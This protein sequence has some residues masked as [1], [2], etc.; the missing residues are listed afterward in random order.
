M[1]SVRHSLAEDWWRPLFWRLLETIKHL[2]SA[3]ER[4]DLSV[5]HGTKVLCQI[6]L[7]SLFQ[8]EYIDCIRGAYTL[9][10]EFMYAR[11]HN[12]KSLRS[13]DNWQNEPSKIV[14]QYIKLRTEEWK[15]N[16]AT[17]YWVS[18]WSQKRKSVKKF[19]GPSRDP[20]RSPDGTG[21]AASA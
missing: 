1:H 13:G 19:T 17:G 8:Y 18:L 21:E 20:E 5:W 2:C 7:Y 3:F 10:R 15:T 16:M 11:V 9:W 14:K 4:H 12:L 6:V